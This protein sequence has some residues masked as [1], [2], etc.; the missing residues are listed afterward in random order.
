MSAASAPVAIAVVV[1]IALA[2]INTLERRI[3]NCLSN[4]R[5]DSNARMWRYP[6]LRSGGA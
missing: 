3:L 6:L 4:L 5:E 1:A 2:I